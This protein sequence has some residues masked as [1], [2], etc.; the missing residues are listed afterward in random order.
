MALVGFALD[1]F[2]LLTTSHFS[3]FMSFSVHSGQMASFCLRTSDALVLMALEF[4]KQTKKRK[5]NTIHL[6]D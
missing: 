1:S 5:I 4:N 3:A 2:T 6:L